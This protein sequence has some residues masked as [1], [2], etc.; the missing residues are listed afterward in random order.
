[1]NHDIVSATC[2]KEVRGFLQKNM[3][4]HEGAHDVNLYGTYYIKKYNMFASD[5]FCKITG[6]STELATAHAPLR[7]EEVLTFLLT[8]LF[9][10]QLTSVKLSCLKRPTDRPAQV[11]ELG[12]W[13]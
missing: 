2:S 12:N 6:I 5:L 13:T 8:G 9:E 11:R 4:H 3:S 10:P 1:M 7:E